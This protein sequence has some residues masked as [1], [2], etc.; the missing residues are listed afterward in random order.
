MNFLDKAGDPI[1][2]ADDPY[3]AIGGGDA[4]ADQPA[5]APQFSQLDMVYPRTGFTPGT[6]L[7]IYPGNDVRLW[8]SDTGGNL[9]D[10]TPN[11]SYTIPLDGNAPPTV[12]VEAIASSTG[13]GAAIN[14]YLPTSGGS[15]QIATVSLSVDN[16]SVEDPNATLPLD[17]SPEGT[18]P[19]DYATVNL[20]LPIDLAAGT[21]VT[22]SIDSSMAQAVNVYSDSACTHAILGKE[23]GGVTSYTWTV[24][25]NDPPT[26]VYAVALQDE[27]WDASMFTLSVTT[28]A[29][30][31]NS[32]GISS[33]ANVS[34]NQPATD[35][36]YRVFL[37]FDDGPVLQTENVLNS[38]EAQR[39]PA[40]FFVLGSRLLAANAGSG[41]VKAGM[42]DLRRM[43][44]DGDL[45]GG[46]S[47]WHLDVR[48]SNGKAATYLTPAKFPGEFAQTDALISELLKQ[49]IP[50]LTQIARL[51]TANTWRVSVRGGQ[52]I[53]K[54]DS[55]RI[56][57]AAATAANL[58]QNAGYEVFG[59]DAE[60]NF[61]LNPVAPATAAI[62]GVVQT[63]QQMANQIMALLKA[64]KTTKPNEL[65]LLDHDRQFSTKTK[66]EDYVAQLIIILKKDGVA[67]DTLNHY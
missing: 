46:H 63:P 2:V 8:S 1:L 45:I 65:V 25:G 10:G 40:S 61:P 37:T 49:N 58:L 12:Y 44:A 14:F 23:A 13:Y 64:G 35:G 42:K 36:G 15:I 20:N 53:S 48:A 33:P 38:L 66:T 17:T 34:A 9:I 5:P 32:Y 52:N 7:A 24:A 30:S 26:K 11:Q 50:S 6:K 18:A 27:P 67:F 60:W 22:L 59:W 28:P 39:V 19:T 16:L 3:S 47:F 41:N 29:V 51:P 31:S 55:G 62:P 4:T 56:K 54:D 21:T 43:I 57:N